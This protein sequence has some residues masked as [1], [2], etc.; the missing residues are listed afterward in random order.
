MTAIIG[1]DYGSEI[2][3]L[4]D[5]RVSFGNKSGIPP[6]DQLIK[7]V[8]VD[9]FQRKAVLG[10]SGNILFAKRVIES[11]RRNAK[12]C[13]SSGDLKEDFRRWIEG[14]IK[15]KRKRHHLQFMLCDFGLADR[16][17]IYVYDVRESG[18]VHLQPQ[19]T[20]DIIGPGGHPGRGKVAVIGSG[21]ELKQKIY[22]TT[23][24]PFGDPNR[25]DDYEA[26]SRVRMLMVEA[27]IAS[28]FQ[29]INSQDVGG[30][31]TI[32]RLRAN[33]LIGPTYTWPVGSG[34]T[35][36]VQFTQEGKRTVLSKPSTGEKYV[37]YSI[38][39]YTGAD[40]SRDPDAS[41]SLAAQPVAGADRAIARGKQRRLAFVGCRVLRLTLQDPRGGSAQ[42]LASPTEL[43]DRVG[44]S[45]RKIINV[46]N[47][48]FKK[49]S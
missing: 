2:L 6:K 27:L 14:A 15:M 12:Y 29:G 43:Q 49:P 25:Y 44:Q 35:S 16:A 1:A 4:A 32:I 33:A 30:P 36:D 48:A 23:L 41:A 7:L 47:L 46:T 40:F 17:H 45:A 20:I 18:E 10:F 9:F 38:F 3:V 31:F 11:L 24:R 42:P 34:D 39:D 13:R 5:T 26:Y 8:G 37:L 22:G 19:G 21:S 28:E